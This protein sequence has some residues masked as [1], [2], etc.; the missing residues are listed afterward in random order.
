MDNCEVCEVSHY[1]ICQPYGGNVTNDLVYT[2]T[3]MLSNT[4]E[5]GKQQ[6]TQKRQRGGLHKCTQAE[7]LYDSG[8]PQPPMIQAH[9]PPRW[10]CGTNQE[11]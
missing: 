1:T 6:G 9:L 11:S 3:A 2:G 5:K 8:G 4:T 7:L 10:G